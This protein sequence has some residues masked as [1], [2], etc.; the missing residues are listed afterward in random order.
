MIYGVPCDQPECTRVVALLD[1][2]C[3]DGCEN[4]GE[5]SERCDQVQA[6]YARQEGGSAESPPTPA[7]LGTQRGDT[8]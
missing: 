7:P 8:E 2:Y 1:P 6:L 4:G 3:C 5:H